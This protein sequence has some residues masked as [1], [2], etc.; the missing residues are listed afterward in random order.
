MVPAQNSSSELPTSN[1]VHSTPSFV[2]IDNPSGIQ[3]SGWTITSQQS[4]IAS[5]VLEDTISKELGIKLPGMLFADT[6]LTLKYHTNDF[7]LSFTAYEALRGVGPADP[8]IRVRA[9]EH[10]HGRTEREDVTI[11]ELPNASDWTFTTRYTGT[12]PQREIVGGGAIDYEALRDTSLPILYSAA[13]ILFE[14]EL[15]DN[16]SASFKVRIR[17]M[18]GFFFV[19]M[20]FFLRVDGVLARVFDTRYFHKFGD[21]VVVREVLRKE[22]RLRETALHPS[23]LRD[24]D[25]AASVLPTVETVQENILLS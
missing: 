8:S 23:M 12:H 17:V 9:A 3:I 22:A 1:G 21:S 13:I 4:E 11:G 6:N 14:D 25:I 15:D 7:T 10:W 18:P 19:L 16:G 24:D 5:T 20:R 2:L